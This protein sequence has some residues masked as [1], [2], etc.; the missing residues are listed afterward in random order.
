MT[1]TVEYKSPSSAKDEP[2]SHREIFFRSEDFGGVALCEEGERYVGRLLELLV[3]PK[4]SLRLQLLHLALSE[5]IWKCV[6]EWECR[7]SSC[8]SVRRLSLTTTGSNLCMKFS[9]AV[10]SSSFLSCFE[11]VIVI[12]VVFPVVCSYLA[13]LTTTIT[14]SALTPSTP[15]LASFYKYDTCNDP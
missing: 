12:V 3:I 8:F 13:M 11:V 9:S 14:H 15:V 7:E 5:T 6:G 4:S 1:F 2:V 10:V